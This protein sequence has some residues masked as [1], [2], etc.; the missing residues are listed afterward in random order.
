M[1]DFNND[2]ETIRLAAFHHIR[3]LQETNDALTSNHLRAGFV[4]KGLRVPLVNPQR[5]IFKPQ[6]MQHLL[7]IRTVYPRSGARGVVRRPASGQQ[8]DLRRRSNG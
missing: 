2:D 5:G 1:S 7:S 8:A 3:L 6:R 4:F